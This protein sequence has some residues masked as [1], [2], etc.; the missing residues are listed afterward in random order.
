MLPSIEY[1][2]KFWRKSHVLRQDIWK[3]SKIILR[4]KRICPAA[5]KAPGTKRGCHALILLPERRETWS[6]TCATPDH[7]DSYAWDAYDGSRASNDMTT[8]K[9]DVAIQIR[10]QH[11]PDALRWPAGYWL[12][13]EALWRRPGGVNVLH[14]HITKSLQLDTP[15]DVLLQDKSQWDETIDIKVFPVS[16]IVV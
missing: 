1:H 15:S 3:F 9:N 7:L 11:I 4:D 5:Q 6:N 14:A 2:L 13:A 12:V 16:F 10:N 8:G